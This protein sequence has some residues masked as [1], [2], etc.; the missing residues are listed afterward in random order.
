MH[1]QQE[2]TVLIV[3]WWPLLLLNVKLCMVAGH[4]EATLEM[5][6]TSMRFIINEQHWNDANRNQASLYV[7]FLQHMLYLQQAGHVIAGR[8]SH[9]ALHRAVN[10]MLPAIR[11]KWQNI[12]GGCSQAAQAVPTAKPSGGSSATGALFKQYISFTASADIE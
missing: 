5:Y 6:D 10:E 8:I 1:A 11:S 12:H 7:G 9:T 4:A 2:R 3:L